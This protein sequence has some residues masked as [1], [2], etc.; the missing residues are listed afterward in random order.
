MLSILLS[1]EILVA[2]VMLHFNYIDCINQILIG[3]SNR[4]IQ[5]KT[6]VV[7]GVSLFWSMIG[8]T[9][10]SWINETIK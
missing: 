5:L 2:T 4:Q 3:N 1:T 7:V 6:I 8:F 9:E 10:I